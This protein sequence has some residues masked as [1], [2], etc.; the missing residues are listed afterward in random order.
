MFFFPKTVET[1]TSPING[2]IRV[3][4]HFGRFT[5]VAG[6][7]TQSGGLVLAIWDKVLRSVKAASTSEITKI[8]ILGL[9]AGS[10]ARVAFQLWRKARITG[11]EIDPVMLE[12][13]RKY[14]SLHSQPNLTVINT[15][16]VSWLYA[17]RQEQAVPQFD[18]VLV[19]LY[20]GGHP[21][22]ESLRPRFLEAIR[23]SLGEN[24]QALFNWLITSGKQS[25]H[26]GFR[27][28]LEAVFKRVERHS[29]PANAVYAAYR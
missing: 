17:K 15:D 26:R 13:G 19:D 4:K 2:E 29:S 18:L 21:P 16:A 6:G 25:G 7:Y 27:S 3:V 28:S 11:I 12:L 9:G 1:T 22:Q 20:V 10:A 23:S 24:G 14:F 5:V 8:L